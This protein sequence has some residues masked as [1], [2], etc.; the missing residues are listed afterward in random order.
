M[1]ILVY[2]EHDNV[3]LKS[4]TLNVVAAAQAIGGDVHVLVAGQGAQAAADAAAQIAGVS[5]VLLADNAAYAHQ[6]AENVSLL[7][8]SVGKGYSH[9]L[10]AATSNGKNFLTILCNLLEIYDII[11]VF[12]F[13]EQVIQL[14]HH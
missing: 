4:A 8:A 1:A 2:A 3:S 12:F 9:I 14:P 11:Y 13:F 6:L 7:V 10:A 5:K